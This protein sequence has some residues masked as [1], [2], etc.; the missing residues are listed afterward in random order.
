MINIGRANK[1]D[2]DDKE[3][4]EEEEEEAHNLFDDNDNLVD[5]D[6]TKATTTSAIFIHIVAFQTYGYTFGGCLFEEEE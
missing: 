3:E 6:T 5:M 4:E 1:D 2:D